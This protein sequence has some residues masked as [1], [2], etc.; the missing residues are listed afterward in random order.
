MIDH[1]KLCLLPSNLH[2]CLVQFLQYPVLVIFGV[3]SR[4]VQYPVLVIFGV[5]S[6]SVQYVI[7]MFYVFCQILLF[8]YMIHMNFGIL[9]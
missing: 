3:I 6:R 9:K 4:S 7:N 5:I 2:L 8:L 1:L